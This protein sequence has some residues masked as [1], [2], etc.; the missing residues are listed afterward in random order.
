MATPVNN[1]G[2]V[3]V[4]T[5]YGAGDTSIV[6][7][8][9]H[10][11]RLPSTTG[12][13]TYPLTWWNA[14]DYAHPADDP[15]VEV[16]LVTGR[17][18]DTLTVTRAHEDT[19]ATTKNTAS[20][21][22][23]MSLG[24]TAAMWETLKTPTSQHY[25]LQLQTH[26]DADL[27]ATQVELVDVDAIIMNDGVELRNDNEEWSGGVVDSSITGAGGIDS[28]TVSANT[29]YEIYAI[30][31]EDNTRSLLL[32]QSKSWSIS[33]N[34]ITG[35]DADQPVR[36]AAA[37]TRVAQGF[38]TDSG[39]IPF[40][41]LKVKKAGIPAGYF[42]VTIE[43]DSGGGPSGTALVT[44]QKYDV[45]RLTTTYTW[46]RI[47]FNDSTVSLSANP[48]QYWFVI[49][50]DW[51]INATNYLV[52]HMDGSAASYSNGMKSLYNGSSWTSDSDDDLLFSICREASDSGVVLPAGYTKHCFLGW[53]LTDGSSN[54]LPFL[55]TGR[56]RLTTPISQT[57][58]D[59]GTLD[60]SVQIFD[61]GAQLPPRHITKVFIAITGT[62]T[63]TAVAAVG[64]LA[65]TDISSDGASTG[66]QV[67][68][69]GPS[70]TQR[71]SQPAIVMVQT[72]ALMAHGT[73][74]AQLWVTGFEW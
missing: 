62:G 54:F 40:I 41:E 24:V 13:Y 58:C 8:A 68:M 44:S 61:V 51:T 67:V 55:Q 48:T 45:S 11:S 72:A 46:M 21:T 22:Y 52:I 33:T 71:P 14:T 7:T 35:G 10:G 17:S 50:G 64:D 37:N 30:A 60:G 12:G 28:G 15:N 23:R 57:L 25:G 18:T 1:F 27:A 31:K 70:T 69:Y 6:L 38:K 53:V 26:R 34:Y 36:A 49:H 73:S 59:I 56:T 42:W 3:T 9:G 66:A 2:L 5:G 43:A 63:G 39:P 16:V 47:A 65:A 19:S 29:W 32:H 20:K 74:G 4:N